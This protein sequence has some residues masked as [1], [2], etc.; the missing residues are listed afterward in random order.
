MAAL[1]GPRMTPEMLSAYS[2]KYD[3]IVATG[4]TIFHGSWAGLNAA[5]E[6]VPAGDASCV[7][8]LGRACAPNGVSV[9]AG[10]RVRI[11][12]GIFRWE[13]GTGVDALPVGAA[14]YADTDQ[15]TSVDPG[16]G[17]LGGTVV[18]HDSAGTWVLSGIGLTPNA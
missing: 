17:Q 8:V 14:V 13:T 2:Q 10:S 18:E 16:S 6:A 5:E 7:I 12:Q 3:P 1:T 9:A 11:D 15:D 4:K